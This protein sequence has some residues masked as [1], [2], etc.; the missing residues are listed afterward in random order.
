MNYN[1]NVPHPLYAQGHGYGALYGGAPSICPVLDLVVTHT[2]NKS[3]PPSAV[4]CLPLP[5]PSSS[6]GPTDATEPAAA[7]VQI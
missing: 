4:S 6:P 2:K 3:Y 7:D 5:S 1:T